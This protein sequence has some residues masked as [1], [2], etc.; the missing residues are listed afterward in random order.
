MF[1]LVR[2]RSI[3]FGRASDY[4]GATYIKSL[5][6]RHVWIA[7]PGNA[8]SPL[9]SVKEHSPAQIQE[10]KAKRA[11]ATKLYESTVEIVKFCQQQGTHV[12][13]ELPEKC[14]AWR[15]PILQKLR[16]EMGLQGCV[17]KGCAVG[18][19]GGDGQLMMKGWRL[20]T[21]HA[22]LAE[23]MHK[24]CRCDIHYRHAK[25]EGSN[26]KG[27]G[28][29]TS[30]FARLVYEALRKEGN[31]SGVVQECSGESPLS[32]KFGL[33]YQCTCNSKN[34]EQ[35]CGSCL[36]QERDHEVVG[37]AF[38]SR[39]QTRNL[40]SEAYTMQ[41]DPKQIN[42]TSL[43][44]LLEKH[45]LRNTG[46]SRRSLRGPNDYVLFGSYAHGDKYGVTNRTKAFPQI[47]QYINTILKKL[48]PTGLHWSA[49][50]INHGS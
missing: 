43:Q 34:P 11:H 21:S 19:R 40:E 25:C 26:A 6:P 44:T 13:V 22:R 23:M 36:V 15:L 5:K 35:S 4:F 28:N 47:C 32:E 10:L 14:E 45:P 46:R 18:L 24:P 38:L 12:T 8:Y 31:F 49:F 3:N 30:E 9:Q 29:Y 48:L 16:F 42:L 39:D 17:T 1:A 27:S 20:V 50:V 2:T 33:G 41:Q 37:Q 7:P